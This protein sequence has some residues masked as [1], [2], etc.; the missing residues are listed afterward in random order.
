MGQMGIFKKLNYPF[1]IVSSFLSKK[2]FPV[3]LKSRLKTAWFLLHPNSNPTL[4]DVPFNFHLIKIKPRSDIAHILTSI[5][6]QQLSKEE[7]WRN[8]LKVIFKLIFS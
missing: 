1:G 5:E 6:Q 3:R 2:F 4:I 8:K 7:E